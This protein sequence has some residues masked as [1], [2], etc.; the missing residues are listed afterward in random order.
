MNRQS[1][2]DFQSNETL[3][4]DNIMVDTFVK[5]YRMHSTK[6]ELSCNLR[7]LGDNNVGSSAVINVP[8]WCGMSI[9]IVVHMWGWGFT[10]TLY[11]FYSIL[12]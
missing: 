12:P 5:T 9:V 6:S 3:P 10:G 2:E 4:Y 1:T 7:T 8:S 11:S